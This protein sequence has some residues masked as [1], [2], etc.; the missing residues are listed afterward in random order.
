MLLI[1]SDHAAVSTDATDSDKAGGS[2]GT[3]GYSPELLSY[4]HLFLDCISSDA[5]KVQ[6]WPDSLRILYSE[7]VPTP[8]RWEPQSK[9]ARNAQHVSQM[10]PLVY[11]GHSMPAQSS[12]H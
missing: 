7:L 11:W 12:E 3:S 9:T 8:T 2:M 10:V 4:S 1:S 6:V 5:D